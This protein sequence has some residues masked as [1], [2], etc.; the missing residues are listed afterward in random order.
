MD[1]QLIDEIYE[2]AF[3]P[4][5][6][7]AVLDRLGAVVG[8]DKNCMFLTNGTEAYGGVSNEA[9]RP[10]LKTFIE[11]GWMA[12]NEIAAR[13]LVWGEPAFGN[14]LDLFTREEIE[15]SVYYRDFLRP[16]GIAWCAGTILKSPSG[17]SIIISLHRAYDEGPVERDNISRLTQ[18][19]PHLGRATL[20]SARLRLEEA[21]NTITTLGNLGLPA[22]A[23]SLR[24]QLRTANALFEPFLPTLVADHAERLRF[25]HRGADVLY[26]D[27]LRRGNAGQR[28]GLSFPVPAREPHVP[29]V[30]HLV[31]IRRA[32]Q[33]IFS[34]VSWLLVAIP[35]SQSGTLDTRLLEGLFDLTP[36]EARVA[37][38]ILFGKTL[39][40]IAADHAVSPETTRSQLKAV[41]A[42]TGTAR[43]SE[44]ASLLGGLKITAAPFEG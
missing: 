41:L 9:I 14:D 24:G 39:Q 13:S 34:S 44:L 3:I 1:G 5:K 22:A 18:V 38:G 19:R 23:L 25:V 30:M 29:L 10:A 43:Q 16:Q 17:D 40:Q 31:P 4:E 26:S 2:A 27:A 33:D 11:D 36:A 42:K 28:A 35:V 32:A 6:W 15:A 12:R 20:A 7:E 37:R 21:R 8:C